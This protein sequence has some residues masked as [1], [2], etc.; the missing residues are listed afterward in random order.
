MNEISFTTPAEARDYLAEEIEAI[1][2]DMKGEP[3]GVVE[4]GSK[5]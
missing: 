4:S 3:T 1:K 2:R 5:G